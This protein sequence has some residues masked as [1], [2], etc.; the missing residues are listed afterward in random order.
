MLGPTGTGKTELAV[1]VAER[2]GGEIVGCDALQVYRDVSVG[3]AKPDAAQRR[4]VP[5]HLVEVADPRTSFTLGEYVALAEGAVAEIAARGKVPVVVGGTGMYLR[6]LLRGIVA[7]PPVDPLLRERLKR[8]AARFGSPR[9][10]RW[11][12]ALDPASAERLPPQDGQRVTRALEGALSGAPWSRSLREQGTWASGAERYPSL[13]IGLDLDRKVHGRALDA[14][15]DAFFAAGLV[16]EV[17][18]LLASGVPPEANA[19]KAIGYRQIVRGLARGTALAEI[20]S[21]VKRATRRYA[22]RQRTWFRK[23]PGVTW[24]DAAGP[25]DTRVARIVD[26]WAQRFP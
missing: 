10:H 25:M 16:D 6:G 23:E 13:K 9:L 12:R 11:L 1:G 15:V 26:L 2:I 24:L 21:E 17:R 4:R 14:R 18:S 19:L 22:K 5:H 3:T 7:S 8:M 20:V